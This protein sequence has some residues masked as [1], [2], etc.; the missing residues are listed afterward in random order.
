MNATTPDEFWKTHTPPWQKF[1]V[2]GGAFVC[3]FM[4][5]MTLVALGMLGIFDAL[6]TIGLG[7]GIAF[8]RSRACAVLAAVF[9]AVS[10]LFGRILQNAVGWGYAPETGAAVVSYI[11]LT[12]L[13]LSIYGTFRWQQSYQDYIADRPA[14]EDSSDE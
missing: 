13:V 2:L 12:F 4:G 7:F 1:F 14:P 5:F 9:Y 6:L 8:R 10:Q 11:Y 3:F